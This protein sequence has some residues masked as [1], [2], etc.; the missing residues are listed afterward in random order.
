MKTL[1]STQQ[2][3]VLLEKYYDGLTS[4][5]EEKALNEFL[6][7]KKLPE[8]F[9]ADRAISGYFAN[10]KKKG[11]IQTIPLLRWASVAASVAIAITVGFSLTFGRVNSFAYVDGKKVTDIEQIREQAFAS[12]NSWN[13][14][15]NKTSSD[16]DE[17]IIQQLQLFIK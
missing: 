10:Q 1:I 15:E 6:S 4:V 8:Q 11:K 17:L 7:Q 2:A 12:I 16:T 13:N 5:K 3:T 14:I 9:E